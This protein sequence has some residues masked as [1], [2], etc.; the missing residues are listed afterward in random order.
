[1]NH[2]SRCAHVK[3]L[4]LLCEASSALGLA[5][6]VLQ[7]DRVLGYL[8]VVFNRISLGKSASD[9]DSEPVP[10]GGFPHNFERSLNSPCRVPPVVIDYGQLEHG[11]ER[12]SVELQ[13]MEDSI[14]A[15]LADYWER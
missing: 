8:F 14:I 15:S 6:P 2:V 10:F 7:G 1:V 5:V 11:V 12:A 3:H 9:R 13:E 4:E